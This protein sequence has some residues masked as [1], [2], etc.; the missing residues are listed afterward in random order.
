[1]LIGGMAM[2][3]P[4]PMSQCVVPEGI[5][6]PV[7][8]WITSDGQP[9]LNNLRDRAT[10]QMIAGPTFAF[11]DTQ[12]ELLGQLARGGAVAGNTGAPNESTSTRT[13]SPGEASSILAGAAPTG[14]DS[15]SATVTD[16]AQVT[17]TA[18]DGAIPTDS[19]SLSATDSALSSS[20]TDSAASGVATGSVAS[21]TSSGIAASQTAP[22]GNAASAPGAGQP[23]G[24]NLFTGKSAD[25]A[26]TVNGWT[27][28]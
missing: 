9:L 3:I 2:S 10:T 4:L 21:G 14:T 16:S 19:A 1:M 6:G 23:G 24:P 17:G 15:A 22:T 11:I 26:I 28:A 18:T 8:I 13:I 25:G 12:P 7:A 20:A 27:G 5:N